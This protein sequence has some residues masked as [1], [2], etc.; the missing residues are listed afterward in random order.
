MGPS[1]FRAQSLYSRSANN[2]AFSENEETVNSEVM[3]KKRHLFTQFALGNSTSHDVG[4]GR[5]LGDQ[6][7]AGLTLGISVIYPMKYTQCKWGGTAE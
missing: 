3:G 7:T 5:D 2:R 4:K 1:W 6:T